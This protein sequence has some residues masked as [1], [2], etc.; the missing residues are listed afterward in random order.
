METLGCVGLVVDLLMML[1]HSDASLTFLFVCHYDVTDQPPQIPVDSD[2]A[3]TTAMSL[4]HDEV[5]FS[6]LT[7]LLSGMLSL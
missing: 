6:S 7:L 3:T 1:S 2:R 5:H 4:H